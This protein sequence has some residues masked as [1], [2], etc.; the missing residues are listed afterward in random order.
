MISRDYAIAALD[1]EQ[2]DVVVIGGG[3]TG[4]GVALDA[5]SRGYSVALLERDDFSQGTSSRSS[6][7][8]HGGLR[9]L[10][11]FD[12][13]LVR[14]ALLERQLMVHLA[15]HLVYPTPYLVPT[16]G[17]DRR[18]LRVGIGLNA[19][20]VM[21]TSRIG[22]GRAQREEHGDEGEF[23]SPDRHRTISGEEAAALSPALE[24]LEPKSA[25]LFYDCQ[26]DDSRLVLTI[27]GEAERFGA[28]LLNG[29]EVTEILDE[30]GR[31]T[32]VAATE[33]ESGERLTV[34]A[35]NVVNATGV[36]ADRIRPDEILTEEEIP[37]IAPSRGTH[38][39][40]STEDLP[41]GDAAFVVPAG[42]DR[43]V[44]ILPWYGRAMIGPT[45]NDYDGDIDY[46]PPSD[47]DIHYLLDAVND[48]LGLELTPDRITGAFA[49]VRPLISAG[50]PRKSVDIS[51]KAELYETSSGMLTITGGKLTT[52]RRMAEMTVD[53]IVER[54][55]RED[56]SRTDDIPL[57]M[58]AREEDLRSDAALPE[59][60]LEQLAFRYGHA[61]R[62]VLDLCA[63]RPELAE[64]ILPGH[65]D[66][67]AEVVIAARSEQARSIAD[68]LMRRTRLGLVAASELRGDEAVERVARLLGEEHAWEEAR[69]EQ[70]VAAWREAVRV[71]GLDPAAANILPG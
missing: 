68:V 60:A 1:G 19:Y 43:T 40:L 56:E 10:Q 28:V 22:R 49:G 31:A 66:L 41:V 2:F 20:D 30:G 46:V 37:R 4:A 38:I 69:I 15:P 11:N 59:G 12:L 7:M 71:E 61:S 13:G 18:D 39:T 54:D 35:S 62:A 23:W 29:A 44:M 58:P 26:T 55:A 65:P 16:L 32:G 14:E 63:E 47:G 45:D 17:D 52:W 67:L 33:S 9:Y 36:W 34:L 6:K 70:E 24:P 50:D 27:L 42:D 25:Y 3:I 8:V 21:A 57:G 51:R 53:R 48:Y 5:A 64:P